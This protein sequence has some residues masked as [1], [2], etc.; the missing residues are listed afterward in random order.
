MTSEVLEAPLRFTELDPEKNGTPCCVC[1]GSSLVNSGMFFTKLE[2]EA[3]STEEVD[4]E[5]ENKLSGDDDDSFTLLPV[6]WLQ[7]ALSARPSQMVAS[8]KN[9]EPT[10]P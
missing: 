9:L 5:L 8:P 7:D 2:A 10:G 3:S 6:T 4:S 1:R